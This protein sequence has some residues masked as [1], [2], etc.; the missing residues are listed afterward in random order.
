MR[1]PLIKRFDRQDLVS[2]GDLPAW[3][4]SFLV[5]LNSFIDPVARALQ[6]RLTFADNFYCKVTIQT[7]THATELLVSVPPSMRVIGAIPLLAVKSTDSTPSTKN[8]ISGFGLDLKGNGQLGVIINFAGGSG[9][10]SD[11]TLI[12]L[13][14]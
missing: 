9:I 13:F 8:V 10:K 14:G 3:M 2:K 12:I 6:G 1:L 4:D 11:V 5:T 7:F